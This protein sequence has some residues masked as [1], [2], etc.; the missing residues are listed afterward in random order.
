[1]SVWLYLATAHP[2]LRCG[3]NSCLIVLVGSIIIG[4]IMG[5]SEHLN[6]KFPGKK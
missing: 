2:A 5:I 1:M 3:C 4:I 6:K